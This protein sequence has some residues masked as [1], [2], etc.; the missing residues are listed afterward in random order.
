METKKRLGQVPLRVDDATT[1]TVSAGEGPRVDPSPSQRRAKDAARVLDLAGSIVGHLLGEP[2]SRR[3]ASSII[4]EL[5]ELI[6]T[7]NNYRKER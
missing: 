6:E 5:A 7:Y 3:D 2:L 1:G 4:D